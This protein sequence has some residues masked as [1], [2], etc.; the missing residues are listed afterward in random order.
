MFCVIHFLHP[1]ERICGFEVFVD[2]AIF[3]QLGEVE[4]DLSL[5]LLLGFVEVLIE[6]ARGE[7]R[8]VGAAAVLLERVEAH[9]TVLA[10]G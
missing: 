7:K 6:R 1:Q 2:A 10:D 9:S 3:Y 5:C 4:F 8:G